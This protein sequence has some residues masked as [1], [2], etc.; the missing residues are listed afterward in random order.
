[1][2][3]AFPFLL[4][5]LLVAAPVRSWALK[6]LEPGEK[7][8]DFTLSD[9]SGKPSTLPSLLGGKGALFVFWA[10][11]NPRSRDVFQFLREMEANYAGRDLRI[12]PVNSEKEG[13]T[14]EEAEAA[15]RL[16]E[17]WNLPWPTYFD[18][19]Y[20]VYNALGII[21]L[22]TSV[23][24]GA[25]R[26][27]VGFYPGFPLMAR[28]EIPALVEMG[29]GP[30]ERIPEG[31]QRLK[32]AAYVP[33]NNAGR[34]FHMARLLLARKQPRK[35]LE[36]ME[37]ARGLDPDW[38]LP[39]LAEVFLL[40]HLDRPDDAR[41]R[42]EALAVRAASE[43]SRAEIPWAEAVGIA[44]LILGEDEAALRILAPL[45]D[46]EEPNPRGLLGLARIH[47]DKG[48]KERA[49]AVL[50]KLARWPVANGTAS[51]D[52]GDWI[53]DGD[54]SRAVAGDRQEFLRALAGLAPPP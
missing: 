25:D 28:D 31:G 37:K 52:L 38:P 4:L 49:D 23:Y 35:A 54:G 6:S 53:A 21:T 40:H 15:L 12:V 18:R 9:A 22:P 51:V 48:E 20:D 5:T 42:T 45:L 43:A 19:G 41:S 26:R 14:A 7:A 50:A 27:L 46:R 33:K 13:S 1:M 2:R 24:I 32:P 34:V 36:A 10:S 39:K 47:H 16:Y 44:R 8:P 17:E 30:A 29:L 11:W 3:R